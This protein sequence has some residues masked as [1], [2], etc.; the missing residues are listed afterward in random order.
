MEMDRTKVG[1]LHNIKESTGKG[2]FVWER[3]SFWSLYW[4]ITQKIEQTQKMC[5]KFIPDKILTKLF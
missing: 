5:V 3:A 1:G 2:L 4:N